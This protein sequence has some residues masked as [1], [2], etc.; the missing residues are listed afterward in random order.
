MNKYE[1]EELLEE[2][3]CR[4]LEVDSLEVNAEMRQIMYF[5]ATVNG[6]SIQFQIESDTPIKINGS[7]R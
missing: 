5:T 1:T 7:D 3:D 6:Q 2:I 4:T